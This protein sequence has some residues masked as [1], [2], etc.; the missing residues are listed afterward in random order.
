[1]GGAASSRA[2][3]PSS[4]PARNGGWGPGGVLPTGTGAAGQYAGASRPPPAF[5]A[6][7]GFEGRNGSL[8]RDDPR[9]TEPYTSSVEMWTKRGM[10]R[11]LTASSSVNTP[12]TP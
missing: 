7:Y 3:A 6:E 5:D 1:M 8:S 9:S 11:S 10:P 12:N 4:N 2:A